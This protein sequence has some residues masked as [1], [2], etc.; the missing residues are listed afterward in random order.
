MSGWVLAAAGTGFTFLATTIGAAVVFFSKEESAEAWDGG[1]SGFA[2]G[3]MVAASV[4]SLLLPAIEMAGPNGWVPALGGIWGGALFLFLLETLP[5]KKCGGTQLFI[6]AVTMHNIPEG[7]AVGLA[8]ALAATGDGMSAAGAMTLALGIGIQNLP[9]GA[10]VS[11][12]LRR[13]GRG[14]LRSFGGGVLSGAV[15]PI[16][17]MLAVFAAGFFRPLMPVLLSFAAGAMLYAIAGELLP[18]AVR[19]AP[20]AAVFG[21]LAGFSIMM[22]LD[23]ALG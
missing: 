14:K 18:G 9:E 3:V 10:A 17:G 7:M 21:F 19:Q 23:V 22:A 5:R 15:E 4:W 16:G 11:L 2:A 12:P 8:C 20:R 13:E 1:S 6:L